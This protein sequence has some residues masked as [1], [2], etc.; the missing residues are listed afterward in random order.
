M[1][2]LNKLPKIDFKDPR[3]TNPLETNSF[4]KQAEIFINLLGYFITAGVFVLML[5]GDATAFLLPGF[6]V[7]N[8]TTSM[9]GFLF[10]KT[11]NSE[12]TGL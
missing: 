3:E 2:L 9:I 11:V 4:F 5:Q 12:K 1:V 7:T 8:E 6:N 10:G